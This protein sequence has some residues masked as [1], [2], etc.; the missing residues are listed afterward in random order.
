MIPEELEVIYL[1][2]GNVGENPQFARQ[3]S[4]DL[5]VR[6]R[7]IEVW[8]EFLRGNHHD[9][10]DIEV[11]YDALNHLPDDGNVADDLITITDANAANSSDLSPEDLAQWVDDPSEGVMPDVQVENLEIGQLRQAV[12]ERTS[13]MRARRGLPQLSLPSVRHTPIDEFDRSQCIFR[14]AFPYLYRQGKAD[15]HNSRLRSIRLPEYIQHCAGMMGGLQHTRY[16]PSWL[17]INSYANK[18]DPGARFT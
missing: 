16:S 3:H 13:A 18:S 6:R 12:R 11:D 5:K 9:Y 15:F 17:I 2:P 14:C 8:L 1:K 10:R 4:R 7:R